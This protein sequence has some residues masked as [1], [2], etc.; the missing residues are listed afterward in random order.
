MQSHQRSSHHLPA[1]V[2]QMQRSSY[3][4]KKRKH[5]RRLHLN[6]RRNLIRRKVREEGV[7]ALSTRRRVKLIGTA[8]V[9]EGWPMDRAAKSFAMLSRASSFLRRSQREL[10]A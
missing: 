2:S 5:L 10:I 6:L 8:H 3:K 4:R 1:Q 9:W 7:E